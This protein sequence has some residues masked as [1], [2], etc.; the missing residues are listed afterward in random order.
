MKQILEIE[1]YRIY[2]IVEGEGSPLLLLHSYWGSH[3]LFDRLTAVLSATMRVIRIDL[4]GHGKSGIPPSDYT[5]EKFAVVLNTLLIRLDVREQVSIIGHSMGGYAA[6]AFARQYPEKMASL[7]L[8]HSPTKAADNQSI[9]LREREYRLLRKGK[10]DLLLQ[11]T[12]PSNF[13][14]ENLDSME[15]EISLLFQTSNLITTEGALMSIHAINH[16]GNSLEVLQNAKYPILIIIGKYDK[17]YSAD[18]QLAEGA[19]IPNAEVMLLC[20]SG[21]L[22]FLEEEFLV[23]NKLLAF[24]ET[25][26]QKNPVLPK[27]LSIN[28]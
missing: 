13:A 4:P 1:G 18:D 22:G 9:K 21:H 15:N 12:I 2:T 8:M 28:F 19:K 25:N 16:R 23:G 6:M 14:S 5:F 24:L 20:H 3:I 26:S 27:P 11:V 17:V 10:K 7:V